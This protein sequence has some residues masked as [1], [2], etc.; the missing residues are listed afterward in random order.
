MAP[1][2]DFRAAGGPGWQHKPIRQPTERRPACLLLC[3]LGFLLLLPAVLLP[4]QAVNP[5][6][7]QITI[8]GPIGPATESY[9]ASSFTRA[10]ARNADL[11]VLRIDTAGGLVSSTRAIVRE[12]LASPV[13]VVGFVHP[14]GAHA[15]SAGTYILYACHLAAMAPGTNVGSATPIWITDSGSSGNDTRERKIINDAAAFIRS[16]AQL[17]G[18]NADWAEQAVREGANL[19]VGDAMRL[20][21]INLIAAGVPQLLAML[22]GREV[23]VNGRSVTLRLAGRELIDLDPGLRTTFLDLITDPTIAYILLLVGL[24]GVMFELFS[25]GLVVPGV[26]GAICLLAALY[27]FQVLPVNLAGAALL[28]VGVLLIAIEFTMPSIG[29]VGLGGIIAFVAGSIFLLDTDGTGLEVSRGVIGGFAIAAS[30]GVAGF[31]VMWRRVHR[32]PARFGVEA[33]IDSVAEVV[34]WQG[35][36][37]RVRALGTTWSARSNGEA[38]AMGF[39][40]G[41]QVR[42][43]AVDGLTVEVEPES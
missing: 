12:I 22:D 1:A 9:I 25:P 6:V 7:A 17:H 33:L 21:V 8:D 19:P 43:T 14:G 13:P 11:V 4:A 16:L 3:L 32:Q 42:I 36:R 28:V 2:P 35:D 5:T 15:G 37:G 10:R 38:P 34:E 40:R 27:A 41:H 18:R 39:E 23:Q 20:G 24:A 29:V 30:A 31:A 26:L